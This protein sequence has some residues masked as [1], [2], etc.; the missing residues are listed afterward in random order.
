MSNTESAMPPTGSLETTHLQ[1]RIEAWDIFTQVFALRQGDRVLCLTD[2]L[3]DPR[4]VAAVR[5]L[6]QARG[7][8]VSVYEASHPRQQ[9]IPHAVR[10]LVEQATLVISTWFCSVLDPFCIAQRT[11]QGQRWVKLTY[12]RNLDL[13]DRPHAR[14]PLSVLSELIRATAAEI[15]TDEPWTLHVSDEHG[16]D[17]RVWYTTEM[18]EAL[19]ETSRWK[20]RLAADHPGAY[21]HYLPTHGP[22]LYQRNLALLGRPDTTRLAVE[23]VI[24]PQ[25][26][27]GF[28]EPFTDPVGVHFESD[29]IVEVTGDSPAASIL[30]KMLIGGRLIELGCGFNPAYPRRLIYPAGSN[31]AGALHYGIDLAEPSDY[32]RRVLPNWEEPPIHMDLCLFDATVRAGEQTLVHEGRLAALDAPSVVAEASH[33]GDPVALLSSRGTRSHT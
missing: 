32:L 30:A 16:T 14:F 31:A 27:I 21:V 28:P 22:N 10:P 8:T 3:L 18:T 9:V 6:A 7:A 23:G 33:Y 2:P 17:F 20:G 19:L 11:Q 26:A 5:G 1:H 24:Y 12:F 15:P 29:Q 13:L 4:V 25:W